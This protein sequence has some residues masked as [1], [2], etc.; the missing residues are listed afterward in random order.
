MPLNFTEPQ[1]KAVVAAV[2]V[3]AT[4]VI[5]FA[6]GSLLWLMVV[7][8]R[9]FSSV[10]LPLAVGAVMALVLRP[11]Y[12]WLCERMRLPMPIALAIVFLSILV[13][14]GA[15]LWFF[16][17]LLMA[18]LSDMLG[19]A[20]GW[21]NDLVEFIRGRWPQIVEFTETNPVGQRI[22]GALVSQQAAL[23]QGLQIMGEKALSV[24]SVVA[25]G[26]GT[27]FSWAVLP[28]YFAYFLTRKPK[29]VNTESLL[30]FLKAETR[31]DVVYLAKEFVDIIV[32]FF[33]GQLM[34]AFLQGLFFAAGFG[35]AGLRYGIVIGLLLGFLNIIPYLGSIVGLSIVLPVA[36]FQAGGG[37]EMLLWA[38]AVF[39]VVQLIEGYVLT[40][41]IMGNRTGLHFMAIIVAIFFWGV[42]LGGI[43]GMILAIPLTAFLVSFWHLA[44]EKYIRELV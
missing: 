24:G 16:G 10:F 8:L 39:V 7:F 37:S 35:L 25:Y 38:I 6:V 43:L 40:P 34:I 17:G 29:Q 41:T 18:Q 23:V 2:T 4:G 44:R 9:T 19:K 12:Q 21:W 14:L 42:A 31:L 5:L 27:L 30:P 20:P 15:F 28:I 36:Y 33:R 13:P 11:Y 26:I 22:R 32:V 3:L 1:A